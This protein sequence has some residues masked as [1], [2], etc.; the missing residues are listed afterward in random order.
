M[1]AVAGLVVQLLLLMLH[2]VVL[3]ASKLML[4]ILLSTV[5]AEAAYACAA[6]IRLIKVGCYDGL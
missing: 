1:F 4:H 6:R 2:L 5:C 3:N